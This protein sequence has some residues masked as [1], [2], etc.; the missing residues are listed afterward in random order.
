MALYNDHGDLQ[1]DDTFV[2]PFCKGTARIATFWLDGDELFQA[3][4]DSCG[5][6]SYFSETK[7]E[8]LNAWYRLG[9]K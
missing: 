9:V 8:A 3:L 1:P 2:C 5:T 6:P 4:C 7:E